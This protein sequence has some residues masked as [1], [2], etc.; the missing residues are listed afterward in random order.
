R[1]G[2][3][4]STAAR[5]AVLRCLAGGALPPATEAAFC[6][7]LEGASDPLMLPAP[8]QVLWAPREGRIIAPLPALPTI[9]VIGGFAGPGLRT[10]ALDTRFA[11]IADLVAGLHAGPDRADLGRIA[12]ES[13]RR[14]HALR[15][16]P[17]PAPLIAAGREMGALGVAVAHTGTA[18]ALLFAPGTVPDAAAGTL[19]ALG[20]THITAFRSGG[21]T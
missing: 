8:G 2:A 21:K 10:D 5:L 15:G 3:G 13:A 18:Q 12:S 1:G 7:A 16:A 6:L 14:N 11:D 20:L 9:E 19:R 4:A 17:D